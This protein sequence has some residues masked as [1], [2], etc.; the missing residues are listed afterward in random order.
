MLRFSSI[1]PVKMTLAFRFFA[2]VLAKG[3][4]SGWEDLGD[5]IFSSGDCVN[6][7]FFLEPFVLQSYLLFRGLF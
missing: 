5:D 4:R 3:A 7:L 6:E 2:A 1:I